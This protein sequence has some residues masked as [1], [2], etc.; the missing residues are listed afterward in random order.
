[1]QAYK[2]AREFYAEVLPAV[3]RTAWPER[4]VADQLIRAA[5]SIM[6]NIAEGAGEYSSPEK[7]RFYRM[8]RRSAWE[9]AAILDVL[10]VGNPNRAEFLA[11]QHS[12]LDQIS[13]LLTTM[14]RSR[15]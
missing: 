14:V 7:A 9:C 15:T 5:S 11:H 8:A 4:S 1:M 12:T 10:E 6:L 2:L 3:R 13:A